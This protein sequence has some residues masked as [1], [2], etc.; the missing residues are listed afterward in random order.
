M[1][2][3]DHGSSAQPVG[4]SSKSLLSQQ[5]GKSMPS[6]SNS[7]KPFRGGS[8]PRNINK[9]N[10]TIYPCTNVPFKPLSRQEF[11]DARFKGS[12]QEFMAHYRLRFGTSPSCFPLNILKTTL[13][14]FQIGDKTA[15]I[16]ADVMIDRMRGDPDH[17]NEL[18]LQ[19]TNSNRV[20]S[21]SEAPYYENYSEKYNNVPSQQ[22]QPSRKLES[23]C[24]DDLLFP[25]EEDLHVETP[26]QRRAIREDFSPIHSCRQ[27]TSQQHQSSHPPIRSLHSPVRSP[28]APSQTSRAPVQEQLRPRQRSTPRAQLVY[29]DHGTTQHVTQC[30]PEDEEGG[31][32]EDS[33]SDGFH[34]LM[35]FDY[36]GAPQ[37][38]NDYHGEY[39]G[40]YGDY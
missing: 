18:M 28:C 31:D 36:E 12:K 37:H 40:G 4:Q 23:S 30:F 1:S 10:K 29:M 15:E 22:P 26:A 13:T 2:G 35:G 21:K 38:Y 33:D 9:E 11:L 25:M 16:E 14:L 5:F 24:Q 8:M 39:D 27:S 6:Q 34:D 19:R 17:Y 3:S 20:R 32:F 7:T